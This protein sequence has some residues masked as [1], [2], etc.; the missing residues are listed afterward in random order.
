[1]ASTREGYTLRWK[2]DAAGI[3]DGSFLRADILGGL[4]HKELEGFV[5]GE[6]SHAQ[7]LGELFEIEGEASPECVVH[8]FDLPSLPLIGSQMAGGVLLI[9]GD[10]GDDVGASMTGGLVQV[11]G[12][13]GSR[14]GG[15]GLGDRRGMQGGEIV[16]EAS[17]GDYAGF[18]MRGGM[19]WIKGTVGLSPGFRMLAGTIVLD[20]HEVDFPGLEM[21]RGTIV[22]AGDGDT[23]MDTLDSCKHLKF[24]GSFD[25]SAMPAA[26]MLARRL[27]VLRGRLDGYCLTDQKAGSVDSCP[28]AVRVWS[29]DSFELN[30]GEIMQWQY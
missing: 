23:E 26:G 4:S 13:A 16:I 25:V 8:V 14:V 18:L 6:G 11:S 29:G 3:V 5:V 24:A 22:F 30:R 20:A 10:V 12:H 17:A 9:H 7:T 27:R 2:G 21:Q 28:V 1:M 19:I 15:P